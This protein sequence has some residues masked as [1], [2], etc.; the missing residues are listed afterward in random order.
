MTLDEYDEQQEIE[1]DQ[2]QEAEPEPEQA[3]SGQQNL[4]ATARR[5]RLAKLAEMFGEQAAIEGDK[6]VIET[7]DPVVLN[8][9]VEPDG[10]L[11]LTW[12]QTATS[13]ASHPRWFDAAATILQP[14]E[15]IHTSAL[16]GGYLVEVQ[17][18][19][20]SDEEARQMAQDRQPI[21]RVHELIQAFP[22][23]LATLPPE[24]VPDYLLPDRETS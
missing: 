23:A 10:G 7:N 15:A 6:L 24:P 18:Q 1:P 20:T 12:W 4:S 21:E 8:I 3:E 19:A 16:G 14:A 22:E 5:E 11:E 9:R 13:T 17:K 2:E